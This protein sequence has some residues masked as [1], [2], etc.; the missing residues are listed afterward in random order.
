VVDERL[1]VGLDS[2][3]FIEA[4]RIPGGFCAEI[5]S[6]AEA[7]DFRLFLVDNVEAECRRRELTPEQLQQIE[8]WFALPDI[9]RASAAT[10]AEMLGVRFPEY[11]V[12][13]PRLRHDADVAIALAVKDARPD[14]FVSGNRRHWKPSLSPLLNGVR[15]FNR[16][17]RFLEWFTQTRTPR[18]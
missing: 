2:C 7:G 8:D 5:L 9:R 13:R 15:V 11:A 4:V 17:R 14:L 18:A 6:F 12:I 16:P 10:P 1:V 3:V